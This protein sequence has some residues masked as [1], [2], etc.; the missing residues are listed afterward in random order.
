M[1]SF[2]DNCVLFFADHTVT[3]LS[4][5]LQINPARGTYLPPSHASSWVGKPL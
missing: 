5:H 4:G 1:S 3:H 2:E